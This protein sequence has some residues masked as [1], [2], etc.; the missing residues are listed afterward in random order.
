MN[1]Q[2]PLPYRNAMA[3]TI[4][5]IAATTALFAHRRLRHPPARVGTL[6]RFADGTSAPVYR[7]TAVRDR[8]PHDP[9]VLIVAFRL[10]LVRG[11]G[12]AL[13]RAESW[14][15][16]PLFVGYPGFVSKL[17]LTHDDR[18]VYRGVYQWDGAEQ[19]A[20]YARCLWRVLAI[21][22]VAG[23]IHYR[24]LPSLRRDDVL[25][26]PHL[27]DDVAPEDTMAW[28]RLVAVG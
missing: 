17:W 12:H 4:R 18:G 8:E 27:L 23:S 2:A 15:N 3:E 5:C 9:C 1:E 7:E 20:R 19:A 28:W 10:R 14:L 6:L 13:F 16:I 21:A 25:D 11:R 26:A 24:V 22:S